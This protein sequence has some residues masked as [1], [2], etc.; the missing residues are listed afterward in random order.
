MSEDKRTESLD[1]SDLNDDD[2]NI[3]EIISTL[4][5]EVSQFFQIP[6]SF[7]KKISSSRRFRFR[8]REIWEIDG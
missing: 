5:A 1:M 3:E 8:S 4:D 6:L 7:G 2:D